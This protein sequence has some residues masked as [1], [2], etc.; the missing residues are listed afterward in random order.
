MPNDDDDC[1]RNT[2]K[3]QMGKNKA[4]Q[5]EQKAMLACRPSPNPTQPC[6]VKRQNGGCGVVGPPMH[7]PVTRRVAMHCLIKNAM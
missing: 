5:K 6:L 7:P 2:I 4:T 1:S 3:T